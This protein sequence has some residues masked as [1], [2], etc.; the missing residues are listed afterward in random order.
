MRPGIH[1]SSLACV[2]S[3]FHKYIF[4]R[5]GGGGHKTIKLLHLMF[6]ELVEFPFICEIA[7][8]QWPKM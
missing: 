8:S 1:G 7:K 6:E 5:G 2:A 4:F 3:V